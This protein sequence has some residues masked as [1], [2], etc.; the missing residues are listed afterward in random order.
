MEVKEKDLK[1]RIED[2]FTAGVL[3]EE[4]CKNAIEAA[5]LP[6]VPQY[7]EDIITALENK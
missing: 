5:G 6:V 2:L 1:T 3:F 7:L 4:T